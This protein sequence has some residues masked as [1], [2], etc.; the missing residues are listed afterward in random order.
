MLVIVLRSSLYAVSSF[1]FERSVFLIRL[2]LEL[3]MG[4]TCSISRII[5]SDVGVS[6]SLGTEWLTSPY[7][8]ASVA[9][10]GVPVRFISTSFLPFIRNG[11]ITPEMQ[12][13]AP[14]RPPE[15]AN[16]DSVDAITI[17]E[18]SAISAPAPYAGPSTND[19]TGFSH[20]KR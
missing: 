3:E 16:V 6:S 17:S 2:K 20:L 12:Q 7:F 5:F 13:G 19:M 15:K 18:A 8:I 9:L 1:V 4:D 11:P 14:T 10:R